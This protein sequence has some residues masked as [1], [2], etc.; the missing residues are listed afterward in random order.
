MGD[1][2]EEGKLK[3]ARSTRSPLPPLEFH[4][5]HALPQTADSS[6]KTWRLHKHIAEN[7]YTYS[8]TL[9]GRAAATVVYLSVVLANAEEKKNST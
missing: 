2:S 3:G 7:I 5:Y 8:L 4:T 9:L 1:D 6:T